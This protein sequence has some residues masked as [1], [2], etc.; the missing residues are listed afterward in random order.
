MATL[1]IGVYKLNITL[2]ILCLYWF[3]IS[4]PQ[5]FTDLGVPEDKIKVDDEKNIL[6]IAESD[7]FALLQ[8]QVGVSVQYLDSTG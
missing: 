3:L 6:I 7:Q 1:W 4:F 8:S 5:I 2:Y